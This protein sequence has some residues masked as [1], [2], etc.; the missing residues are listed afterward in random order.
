MI[1]QESLSQLS[2]IEEEEMEDTKNKKK[3][4]AKNGPV[5]ALSKIRLEGEDEEVS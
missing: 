5:R 4:R 3:R 1:S 2:K